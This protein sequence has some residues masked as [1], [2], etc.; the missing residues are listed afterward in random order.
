P[1]I[2]NKDVLAAA[3]GIHSVEARHAG[4]LNGL[5]KMSPF[6][7]AV[8]SPQT[9]EEV[10]KVAGGFIKGDA[11]PGSP[12]AS[13]GA[14]TSDALQVSIKQFAFTPNSITVPAGGSVTWTNNE[15]IPHTVTAD[16]GSFSSDNLSKGDTFTQTFETAGTITYHCELHMN[17]KA[18]VVVS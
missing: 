11:A 7:D 9:R 17:M 12:A 16:D 15:V 2:E 14:S 6:P 18:E 13:T 8:D 1:S 5:N 4:F 10:L 3:L